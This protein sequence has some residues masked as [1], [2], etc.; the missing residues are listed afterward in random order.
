MTYY[1]DLLTETVGEE[2][3][4]IVGC[5][6]DRL[7]RKVSQEEQDRALKFFWNYKREIYVF[8]IGARRQAIHEYIES[9]FV[10]PDYIINTNVPAI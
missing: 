9:G 5:G 3:G 10:V 1:R 4:W 7:S 8:P 2:E 6:L